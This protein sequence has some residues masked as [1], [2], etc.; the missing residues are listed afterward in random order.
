M[1]LEKQIENTVPDILGCMAKCRQCPVGTHVERGLRL[2][3]QKAVARV[4]EDLVAV[5]F[6]GCHG[7]DDVSAGD[8]ARAVSTRLTDAAGELRIQIAHAMAYHSGT[9]EGDCPLAHRTEAEC[10]TERLIG[11]L[12]GVQTALQ[13]DISAACDGDPAAKSAMEVVLSYPCFKAI[14]AHRIAHVLYAAG[15][16][17]IPRMI[18]E[19]AHLQTGIDIHPGARIGEAFFID[20]G[21]GVVIGETCV[22]GS[23]V[24][25]YQGVTLGALSFPKDEDGKLVKGIKRH[26][27]VEDD[28]IIYG[29]A[30]ILGDVTIGKGSVIGGNVWLTHSVPP[31]SKVYNRQPAPLVKQADGQWRK[32]D[33]P[34]N[35]LGTGI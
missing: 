26:P 31:F 10:V 24:R 25:L 8:L 1:S 11:A 12:P 14:A 13:Q 35:D 34:W 9:T 15:V 2:A 30:T 32:A 6:P 19:Y 16:P 27:N 5:M 18:S 17:L 4:V 33:G 21:T 7:F 23:N 28:V 22:I 20:H 29:G 3:G